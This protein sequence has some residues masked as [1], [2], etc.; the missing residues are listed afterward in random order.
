ML[1]HGIFHPLTN[2]FKDK[3]RHQ[4]CCWIITLHKQAKG[5]AT[6]ICI[7]IYIYVCITWFGALYS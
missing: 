6:R 2:G 7:Y 5:G 1:V 3:L 4:G